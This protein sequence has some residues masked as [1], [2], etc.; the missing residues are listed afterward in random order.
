MPSVQNP[1]GWARA[2]NSLAALISPECCGACLLV[3]GSLLGSLARAAVAAAKKR[4]LEACAAAAAS[5]CSGSLQSSARLHPL[6]EAAE[7]LAVQHRGHP[8]DDDSTLQTGLCI[9]LLWQLLLLPDRHP[10]LPE[11]LCFHPTALVSGPEQ[12]SPNHHPMAAQGSFVDPVLCVQMHNA[13]KDRCQR[14]PMQIL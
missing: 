13:H 3:K 9:C 8:D 7:A 14:K 6:E 2:E 11:R 10:D 4:R 1:F 12:A 5:R